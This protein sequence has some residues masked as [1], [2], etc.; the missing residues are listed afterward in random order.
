MFC[1]IIL[2]GL[3]NSEG[4]ALFNDLRSVSHEG[5]DGDEFLNMEMAVMGGVRN[6]N[7]NTSH[8][9]VN[10]GYMLQATSSLQQDHHA[11]YPDHSF[12][13]VE[14]R[15]DTRLS[16]PGAQQPL[17]YNGDTAIDYNRS[18]QSL[19]TKYTDGQ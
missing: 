18:Q 5:G 6:Q 12:E 19:D 1:S 9:Q 17:G 3:P 14:T 4:I 8:H 11:M 2:T 10:G 15:L 13:T 16:M 7:L